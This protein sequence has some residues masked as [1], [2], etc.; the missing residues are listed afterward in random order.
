[1]SPTILPNVRGSANGITSSRKISNQLLNGFGFSNG[2]AELALKKPPPLLPISLMTS[3]E[4][5]GPPTIVCWA[6][7]SEWI[8]WVVVKLSITPVAIR[9]IAPITENGSSSRTTTR[10]RSTQKLPSRSVFFRMNPRIS[11]MTTTMPTAADT[12]FCTA[13]PAIWVT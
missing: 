3:C 4:A 7:A 10:V 9:M 5:T 1:M 12:K 2:C 8:R 6:P 11:A 13:R